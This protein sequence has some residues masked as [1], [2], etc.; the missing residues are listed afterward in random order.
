MSKSRFKLDTLISFLV[1]LEHL[2][3]HIEEGDP[4][5]AHL[6][7]KGLIEVG[8][9]KLTK[10]GLLVVAD[11]RARGGAARELGDLDVEEDKAAL[12]VQ[13]HSK[14]KKKR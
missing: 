14:R 9:H 2:G 10:N 3:G 8:A 6:R 13:L 11:Y 7:K 5:L 1:D 12:K 4:M